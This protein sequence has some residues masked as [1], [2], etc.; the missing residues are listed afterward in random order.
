MLIYSCMIFSILNDARPGETE[1]NNNTNILLEA[2][3]PQWASLSR[4]GE[5]FVRLVTKF[6]ISM[7]S[8]GIWPLV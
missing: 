8:F 5:I 7:K 4:K 2:V 3:K 6:A 1:E